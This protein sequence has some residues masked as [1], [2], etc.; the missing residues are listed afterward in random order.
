MNQPPSSQRPS[1]PVGRLAGAALFAILLGYVGYLAVALGPGMKSL[2]VADFFAGEKRIL[3][4]AELRGAPLRKDDVVYVLTTQTERLVPLGFHR[5]SAGPTEPRQMLHADLWAFDVKTGQP[6]WRKRLK[7]F[8][9]GGRID[10]TM[11]GAD[12]DTLWVMMREPVGVSM[13]DGRIVA[14]WAKIEAANP[15]MAGKRVTDDGY[16]AYGGQGLQVTLS[17]S[18]Q[19]VVHGDG[20]KA[21]PREKAPANPPALV[22]LATTENYTSGLQLRGLPIGDARWLGVLTDEEAKALQADPVIPGRDPNEPRG[23][24][25]DVYE[26]QHVPQRLEAQ[27]KPYRVWSA[28][29]T[30]VSQAPKDW[31]KDWPDKWGTRDKFSEYKVL[32]EAPPFLQ[33]GFLSDGHSE[34]PVWLTEPDS[35]LILHH[36]KV[37]SEGRLR[38]ARVSGPAGKVVWDAALP[39]GEMQ[40]SMIGKP[41]LAFVGTEPNPQHDP[42]DEQSRDEHE[43]L[44]MLD[45]GTGA[46]AAFDMTAESIRLDAHQPS[47]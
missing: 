38:V 42:E 27:P 19:W 16:V 32:P 11:L 37:G 1:V 25:Y 24:L 13:K 26:A 4:P 2:S 33:A 41:V 43:K 28:K 40:V 31:P 15:S 7:T 29:R 47:S 14:D 10:F 46:V 23:V 9:G 35:V 39:I 22:A 8:E 3:Y 18:T 45:T 21:E 30:K 36:D 6:A 44:V 12:G 34:Y 20:L 5:R 17:D